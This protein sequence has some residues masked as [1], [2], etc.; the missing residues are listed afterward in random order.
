MLSYA[1]LVLAF[2]IFVGS[3]ATAAAPQ[4][5]AEGLERLEKVFG[6]FDSDNAKLFKVEKKTDRKTPAA[7]NPTSTVH[8]LAKES[9]TFGNPYLS[10]DKISFEINRLT[11][12]QQTVTSSAG[13][14]IRNRKSQSYALTKY[15]LN[16][17][18][19]GVWTYQAKTVSHTLTKYKDTVEET[20]VVVW[21]DNGIE[22]QGT[23][24]L[25]EFVASE[26]PILAVQ[27][28][29]RTHTVSDVEGERIMDVVLTAKTYK[30]VKSDAG[31][32]LP[33]PD[34]SQEVG[35][36]I[37]VKYKSLPFGKFEVN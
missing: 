19:T 28:R 9:Q 25:V 30:A 26:A 34:F 4:N 23:T 36:A 1:K 11:D 2:G 6:K 32:E 22:F 37:E 31:V 13:Q 20:G 33:I 14:E 8:L 12:F 29:S 7:D 35:Q 3:V 17:T 15:S 18:S 5:M 16:L 27:R 10:D 24:G 21:L